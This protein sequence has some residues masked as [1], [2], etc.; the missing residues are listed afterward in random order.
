MEAPFASISSSGV[1][2]LPLVQVTKVEIQVV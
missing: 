1:Q 2:Y